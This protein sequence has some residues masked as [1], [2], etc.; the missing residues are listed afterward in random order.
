MYGELKVSSAFFLPILILQN[1]MCLFPR[2]FEI[3][4]C[5]GEDLKD[6]G[7][8]VTSSVSATEPQHTAGV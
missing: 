8:L 5:S 6:S 2:V 4:A 3:I 1:V 7:L